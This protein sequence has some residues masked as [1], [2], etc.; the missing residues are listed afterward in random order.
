[1]EEGTGLNSTGTCTLFWLESG[2]YQ[3]KRTEINPVVSPG[4]APQGDPG[5]AVTPLN[6]SFPLNH[7]DHGEGQK[8]IHVT[9]LSYKEQVLKK[10][11]GSTRKT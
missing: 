4:Q 5:N 7:A 2:H 1:M 8:R 9:A 6:G 3:E 10:G 11:Q